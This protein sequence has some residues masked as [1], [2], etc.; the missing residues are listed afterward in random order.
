MV[1]YGIYSAKY[2]NKRK[3]EKNKKGLIYS[4]HIFEF[5]FSINEKLT[6]ASDYVAPEITKS[7]IGHFGLN[8]VKYYID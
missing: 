5:M 7:T 3:G 4:Y 1:E 6:D 2:L 8:N